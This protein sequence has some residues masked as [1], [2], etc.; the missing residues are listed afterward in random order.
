M[1]AYLKAKSHM[2]RHEFRGASY[3]VD[4]SILGVCGGLTPTF[5]YKVLL[6]WQKQQCAKC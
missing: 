2:H 5:L 6:Q 1:R 3:I 4:W